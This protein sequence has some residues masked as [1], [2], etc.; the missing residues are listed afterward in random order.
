MERLQERLSHVLQH[1][2]LDID[3]LEFVCSQ[4]MIFI[5]ALSQHIQ[6]SEGFIECLTE[7]HNMIQRHRQNQR[8][9]PEI[10]LERGPGRGRPR[11]V[12]EMDRLVH[13]LEI[14]LPV[15][16]I[17]NLLGV[18][19][20]TLYRRMQDNN[21]SVSALYTACT[22]EE[23]DAMVAEIKMRMPHVGYRLVKGS[24]QAQGHH[25]QWDRVRASMH[26]V[27]SLGVLSR[28]AQ[29]GCVIRRTYSVPCPKYLVHIDTNH[30]LIR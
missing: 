9:P 3:Y 17:A 28:M 5:D 2:P 7:L 8:P 24:L 18:S 11:V 19:Y 30:K 4:E 1:T 14:G 26:R 13:L 6:M 20:A 22:D 29:L 27:D 10:H 25:L 15:A 23:L 16:C 21:L 12:I